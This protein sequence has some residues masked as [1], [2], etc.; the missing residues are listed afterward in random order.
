MNHLDDYGSSIHIF[1]CSNTSLKSSNFLLSEDKYIISVFRY[2]K[3]NVS[4]S[5]KVLSSLKF[6]ED[7]PCRF[8]II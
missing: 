4:K 3:L 5:D 8:N 7:S 2:F 6:E 1:F